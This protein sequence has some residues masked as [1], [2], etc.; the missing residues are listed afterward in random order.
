MTITAKYPGTCSRCGGKITPGQK[1]EWQ[2]GGASYH[3]VCPAEAVKAK[4][5]FDSAPIHFETIGHS[6][7]EAPAVGSTLRV[8]EHGIV[9][10]VAVQAHYVSPDWAADNDW[11]ELEDGG[12]QFSVAARPATDEESAPVLAAE[13]TAKARRE[14]QARADEIKQRIQSE[15]E[16]PEGSHLLHGDRILDTQN[17]YG[18]GDWFVVTA[19]SIWY[20]RNNGMDGDDWSRNNVQTGGAG[21]IGWRIPFDPDTARQ[22]LA[23]EAV[24]DPDA[25]SR[26]K[27]LPAEA[28]ERH[29]AEHIDT[30]VWPVPDGDPKTGPFAVW[31]R[32]GDGSVT[33]GLDDEGAFWLRARC[34]EAWSRYKVTSMSPYISYRYDA[35]PERM[36]Q[37]RDALPE[38][39]RADVLDATL[40]VPSVRKAAGEAVRA[41][42]TE[43]YEWGYGAAWRRLME[44]M[45]E[46]EDRAQ[47]DLWSHVSEPFAGRYHIGRE[48]Y[49][50]SDRD[51]LRLS[52]HEY[53]PLGD[54]A[55][56]EGI[57]LVHTNGES[58]FTGRPWALWSDGAAT[59]EEC[60]STPATP[61]PKVASD[62][63]AAALRQD[64]WKSD[65]RWRS[66]LTVEAIEA[67]E[68]VLQKEQRGWS[69]S[70]AGL[71]ERLT[72]RH[73]DGRTEDL[74]RL[75]E[76]GGCMG[77]DGDAWEYVSLY[78]PEDLAT[79]KAAF[80]KI[81][82]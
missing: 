34:E 18:G 75:T 46:A 7:H 77:E 27:P 58:R 45:H 54:V 65:G 8:R 64:F 15:G 67:Q 72:L 41:T 10:V 80:N 11:F 16:R 4:G 53:L 70:D 49:A 42:W 23:A 66:L 51:A 35:T 69:S 2:R 32:I 21:G 5:E 78:R 29:I 55:V 79:A 19:D 62:L 52:M 44:A 71:L 6:K 37:F 73:T 76:E 57:E 74:L 25:A 47:A 28:Y 50:A 30:A 31:V 61:L 43:E 81:F 20:V 24:L 13:A 39:V 38:W 12:Y 82:K 48:G 17:I 36:A 9:T 14:A 22:I 63:I 60:R 40:A 1:I 59:M 56:E 26:R 68:T 33:A 3:T